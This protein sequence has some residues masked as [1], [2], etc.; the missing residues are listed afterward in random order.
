MHHF[1]QGFCKVVLHLLLIEVQ[2]PRL[3]LTLALACEYEPSFFVVVISFYVCQSFGFLATGITLSK[4]FLCNFTVINQGDH[5]L[6]IR[7]VSD[8]FLNLISDDYSMPL[9][10]LVFPGGPLFLRQERRIA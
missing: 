10:H 1:G 4:L 2:N 9:N 7:S 8:F 3:H 5:F 6:S